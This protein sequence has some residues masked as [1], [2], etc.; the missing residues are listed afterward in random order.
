MPRSARLPQGVPGRRL[1][2]RAAEFG[3][4]TLA[5]PH[6]VAA[7]SELM[8]VLGSCA[9]NTIIFVIGP[10]G[11]GKTT[12][13]AKVE[14]DLTADLKDEL[15][16]DKE[17]IPVVSVEASAPDTGN[18]SWREHF[19]RLL[20]TMREPLIDY[21]LDRKG[22][23]WG[24]GRPTFPFDPNPRA[25][26]AEYQHAVE[27][28]LRH[29]RPRA[30]L[31]DE[32]QHLAKM[33]SGRRLLD[34]LDVIKS[35]A[36]CT[37]I[38]HILVGSYDLLAFRNL[39]GQLARRSIDIHFGRYRAERAGDAAI[40]LNIVR[41]FEGQLPMEESSNLADA[42]EY[43]YERSIGCVG[44]LKEWL[45]R[46]V[47]LALQRGH[48]RLELKD[49]ENCELEVSRCE[50]IASECWDGEMRIG[51]SPETVQR[52]RTRL[53]LSKERGRRFCPTAATR[54]RPTDKGSAQPAAWRTSSEKR[55]DLEQRAWLSPTYT[56]GGKCARSTYPGGRA[57]S[58][59]RRQA[60]ERRRSKA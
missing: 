33:N 2:S 42:W 58:P 55:P 22:K 56:P 28:A 54:N 45:D 8:S 51:A 25:S 40:F 20:D 38:P 11:V 44:I 10:T 5:H 21:K 30:V 41:S 52:L 18:F 23:P 17:R 12:L 24:L 6:L 34:Q 50:K 59:L 47:V 9:G 60:F 14:H 53:G 57:S 31:I 3:S 15:L 4:F 49:L 43:L 13:R 48:K 29:R 7:R 32:A 16:H 35:I 19:R 26:G 36:N 1:N 37:G 39:N 46:G 27:Q